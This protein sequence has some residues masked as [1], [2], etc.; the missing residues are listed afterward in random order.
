MIWAGRHWFFWIKFQD[1]PVLKRADSKQHLASNLNVWRADFHASA[2]K[3]KKQICWFCS[4]PADFGNFWFQKV[5][6][7]QI[8][9][10]F[11]VRD[12]EPWWSRQGCG[13]PQLNHP[14]RAFWLCHQRAPGF[15]LGVDGSDLGMFTTVRNLLLF[16]PKKDTCWMHNW[17]F[18]IFSEVSS[19]KEQI[20]M[21]S[22]QS[23]LLLTNELLDLPPEHWSTVDCS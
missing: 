2:S 12:A 22:Q 9:A 21:L 17:S 10:R 23:L 7:Q 19:F 4:K 16:K 20:T 6:T 8:S 18:S 13:L 5:Q 15:S 11:E 1:A 3:R 14:Q